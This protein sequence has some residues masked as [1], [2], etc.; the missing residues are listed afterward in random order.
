MVGRRTELLLKFF[1]RCICEFYLILWLDSVL[2]CFSLLSP[3][4]A[5]SGQRHLCES[6]TILGRFCGMQ[7]GWQLFDVGER[8]CP[9]C[10]V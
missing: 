6:K 9:M 1:G 8:F 7:M 2:L 10:G 5:Y 4:P 3:G